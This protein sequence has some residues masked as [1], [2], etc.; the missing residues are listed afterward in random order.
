M[1][2]VDGNKIEEGQKVEKI[3]LNNIGEIFGE[4]EWCF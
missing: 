4:F 2:E 3:K 1:C